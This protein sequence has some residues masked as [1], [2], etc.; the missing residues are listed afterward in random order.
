[1]KAEP[2]RRERSKAYWGVEPALVVVVM[3]GSAVALAIFVAY[4]C[5]YTSMSLSSR[6]FYIGLLAGLFYVSLVYEINRFGTARRAASRQR[7]SDAAHSHLFEADAP[8]I[9]VLVP[10]Y[11]EERRVVAMTL[12]SAALAQYSNRRIVLLVDDPPSAGESRSR[13][14]AAVDEVREVLAEPMGRLGAE[15]AAWVA[16]REAGPV[17][18]VD[19]VVRLACHYRYVA[20]WLT[21]LAERLRGEV[22]PEFAHVDRFFINQ[23]VWDL[24][25]F[26]RRHA[27]D[28]LVSRLDI[29]L[30]EREYRRL[31]TLF[32]TDITAFERK[33]FS[34]LSHAPNKAMNLNS[35]IGLM[36]GR[37]QLAPGSA[38]TTIEAAAGEDFDIEVPD[39]DYVLTLD[40]DSMIRHTYMLELTTILLGN[41]RL[42]VAQTPYLT[43]PRSHTALERIAGA[44]TDVQYL[45]HQ[46]TTFFDASYWVGANALIRR[47][48]LS[49]IA[50]EQAEAN[51]RRYKVFIQDHTVIEDT[52]STVDLLASGWRVYNHFSTLA[53]SA[54]PADYGALTIQRNRWSNGGLIILPMLI[55]EYLRGENRRGRFLELMLRANYLLSPVI[56]NSAVFLL[57]IWSTVDGRTLVWM[58]LIMVPYFVLYGL[59]LRHLGYRFREVFDVCA[60]NLMLLPVGFA[61]IAASIMQMITGR[62]GRFTRTPKVVDRTF[63]PPIYFL[64]N[65][66]MSVLMLRYAVDGIVARDYLGSVIPVVNV[67]FYLYGLIRFVG[68]LSG[69]ADVAVTIAR[70]IA[71]AYRP[72]AGYLRPVIGAIVNGVAVAYRPVLAGVI[73]L[74]VVGTPWR[75]G[76]PLIEAEVLRAAGVPTA[77]A[78]G[79]I[80]ADSMVVTGTPR[81]LR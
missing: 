40:A 44:T 41:P 64:F 77:S 33:Q 79:G 52:G 31:G 2:A 42:G 6:V 17:V 3:I 75:F 28:L 16:R 8:S 66:G 45:V 65:V 54:T 34:N 39:A 80:P 19:E 22:T 49:A 20:G 57:M 67:G 74:I 15:C 69:F 78:P 10:S 55:R 12:L 43:F 76:A 14:L 60:L 27:D 72:L 46:G 53:Y 5:F 13:T 9:T 36:G 1:V 50:Y 48:A 29:G 26:Y 35:Y 37:Y 68:F 23:V 63:I 24:A 11:R 38:G 32:C 61:G 62:K 25:R 73:F 30:I 81:P 4:L 51:G 56:G 59:D 21:G 71:W 58:P 70:G 18:L 7:Y 47:S